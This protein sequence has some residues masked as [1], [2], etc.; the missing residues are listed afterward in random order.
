MEYS[1]HFESIETALTSLHVAETSKSSTSEAVQLFQVRNVKLDFPRFNGLNVLEWIFRAEQFFTFYNAPEEQR[2]TIAAIHMEAEVIPWFQMI[3]K[4]NPFQS[5][6]GFTRAS[7][8]EFG[9]SP[10]ECPRYTL[11]KLMQS[12]SVQDY[13]REFTALA[14]R[15]QG[16]IADALFD[17]FL[18]S[19]KID[20]RRDVIAQNPTSLLYAVSLVKLF[21][22]KYLPKNKTTLT[23]PYPKYQSSSLAQTTKS[24][25]LSPLLPNPNC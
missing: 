2:L 1:S 25:S 5:W 10:Y 11:F 9:L 20:I 16:I 21:E 22:E 24:T 14:N 15:V 4:T 8:L 3:A 17:C 23:H 6:I 12:G 18:S 7:E 13:Y 19:L